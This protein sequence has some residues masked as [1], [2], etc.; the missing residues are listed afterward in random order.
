LDYSDSNLTD[1]AWVGVNRSDVPKSVGGLPSGTLKDAM[2]G[3]TLSG[4]TITIPA[5]GV[6]LLTQ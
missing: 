5:R 4:P 1:K 6:L 3:G 2:S